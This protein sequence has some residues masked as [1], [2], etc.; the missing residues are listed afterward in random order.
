[1]KKLIILLLLCSVSAYSQTWSINIYQDVKL[2]F[3]EDDYGNKPYTA[4][5]VAKA[6]LRGKQYKSGFIFLYPQLEIALLS[7]GDYLR[8]AAGA[9]FTFNELD[10]IDFSPSVNLGIIERWGHCYKGLEF[11][12]ETS[13]KISEN[14]R[15]SLLGTLTDRNDIDLWRA[16][17]YV[18]FKYIR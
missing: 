14:F 12:L 10:W 9:G 8:A 16:N 18:G 3:L 2:A 17:T 6:E 7:G 15:I 13:V 11:Q 4:D 1:M 5:V